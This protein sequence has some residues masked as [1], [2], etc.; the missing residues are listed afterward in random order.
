MKKSL[1]LFGMVA[2]LSAGNVEAAEISP[3]VAAKL[4]FS[5]MSAKINAELYD[6][7]GPFY[8]GKGTVD[9]KVFGGSIAGGVSIPTFGGSL[10]AELELHMNADA[11]EN[12]ED[13]GKLKVESRAA[14]AN[15]YYNLDT[16]TVVSPFIGGGVGMSQIK[17]KSE[18]GSVKNNNFAWNLGAGVSFAATQNVS[19][20][21][22]YRYV[23]YGDFSK[24][25]NDEGFKETDKM[26]VT[27]NEF[28]L[29]VRYNF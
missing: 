19:L 16:G 24:T 26:D 8:E 3:Y 20:E 9:D 21:L 18:G 1:M 10:R 15:V 7:L 14:F 27:A 25:E 6:E 12:F 29:G 23:D 11:S 5:D 17:G 13:V 28:Y 2:A 4:T 22:G